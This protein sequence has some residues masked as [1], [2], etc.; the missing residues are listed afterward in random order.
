MATVT[1]PEAIESEVMERPADITAD[2]FF[3][4]IEAQVFKPDRRVLLWDGRISEK[5]AKTAAHALTT[6]EI[7]ATIQAKLPADWL[8]WHE[9]PIQLDPKYVPLPDIV[10]VRGPSYIYRVGGKA[11]YPSVQDVGLIVEVAVTSLP[12]DLTERAEKFARALVPVYWVA[13][14]RGRRIIEHSGPKIVD[15][16]GTYASI[17]TYDQGQVIELILDGSPV[18][19]IPIAELLR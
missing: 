12:K 8:I 9:S 11:R 16:V 14:V 19:T 13:D 2:E 5:M 3:A 7:A 6:F 10:V 17:K 4:M 1:E 18:G 15:G